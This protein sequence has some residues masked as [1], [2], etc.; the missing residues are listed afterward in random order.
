M[1]RDEGCAIILVQ[2]LRRPRRVKNL[3]KNVS[4]CRMKVHDLLS[5]P[6]MNREISRPKSIQPRVGSN[7][8]NGEVQSIDQ[9]NLTYNDSKQN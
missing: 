5:M 7:M 6:E 9:I 4:A 3:H 1:N 2:I 8:A